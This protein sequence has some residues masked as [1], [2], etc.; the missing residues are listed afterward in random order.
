MPPLIRGE[1][2]ARRKRI[3]AAARAADWTCDA[4]GDAGGGHVCA[5]GAFGA[6]FLVGFGG[7]RAL[8]VVIRLCIPSGEFALEAPEGRFGEDFD[9]GGVAGF[10]APV[11]FGVGGALVVGAVVDDELVGVG[12]G[13]AFVGAAVEDA[14]AFEAEARADG[15]VDVFVCLAEGAVDGAPVERV[16]GRVLA[17]SAGLIRGR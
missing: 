10:D 5:A 2:L 8:D 14:G 13:V 11:D 16:D 6:A 3:P 12:E 17:W 1:S 7:G 9:G 4:A 15:G